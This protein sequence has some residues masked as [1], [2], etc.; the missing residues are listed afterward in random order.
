MPP[1]AD[2]LAARILA[3]PTADAANPI[4]ILTIPGPA[5][6]EG[7]ALIE[8]LHGGWRP[9]EAAPDAID[10]IRGRTAAQL[11]VLCI[12]ADSGVSL[13]DYRRFCLLQ[14]LGIHDVILLVDGLAEAEGDKGRARFREL[15]VAY[16]ALAWQMGVNSITIIPVALDSGAGI[17]QRGEG[18]DWYKGPTLTGHLDTL[19][20]ELPERADQPLRLPIAEREGGDGGPVYRGLIAAGRAAPEDRVRVQLSGRE[21]RIESLAGEAGTL[22]EA[23]AGQWVRVTLADAL[24]LRPGDVI[25]AAQSPAEVADQF[26]CHILWAG[27]GSMLP[28]RPYRLRIGTQEVQAMVTALKYRLNVDTLEHLAASTLELNEIGVCNISLD[29]PVAF[30]PYAV[31]PSLGGFALL[32]EQSGETVGA[33]LL[34]FALRRAHNIHHQPVTI[35]RAARAGQ[36]GQ[37][38]VVLWFTGL[39]GAGKSTVANLV[40]QKLYAAGCH[41]YLLDG[42]NVRHGLNRDLGFTDADRVE[43]IRRVAEV[44][45]LM[46]DAGLIVLTAFISPFRAEREQA[47]MLVGQENFFEI[48]IDTPLSVAEQ[49]DVKGLYQKARSGELKNFT[50]IDS[51]YE[52]PEN[53]AL[54]LETASEDPRHSAD[55][56]IRYLQQRGVI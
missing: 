15:D 20:P 3:Y 5:D 43:N 23:V 39:S 52:P 34:H 28:G 47:R 44:A 29:R 22:R 50:G 41:S 13:P 19:E 11:A 30:E 26:E 4:R 53:P 12:E 56:V 38:P 51:P 21:S 14:L 31:N 40:E 9:E 49:R 42:D 8:H 27:A 17:R 7:A 36:K 37:K 16:R 6:S 48:F 2:L 1:L 55:Q 32:D 18:M 35:E 45:K 46:T 33:G 24:D 10:L 54:H 25:S